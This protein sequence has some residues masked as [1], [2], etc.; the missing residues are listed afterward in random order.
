[1]TSL[2][3]YITPRIVLIGIVIASGALMATASWGETATFDETAHIPAGYAYVAYQDYRLNPEHPPIV[4]ILAGIPLVLQNFAFPTDHPAWK[5]LNEQWAIGH[6]FFYE[7][8]NDAD[9]IFQWA[10]VGPMALTLILVIFIYIWGKELIGRWWALLPA[11]LFGLSPSVLGHGHLVTTDVGSSLGIAVALYFFIRYLDDTSPYAH[12]N[13]IIYAGLA[14]GVAQLMKF[15]A[16][17]LIPL[18]VFL[19][20]VFY[21]W[22]RASDLY[23]HKSLWGY[24]KGITKIMVIGYAL[25]YLVYGAVTLNYPPKK[26]AEDTRVILRTFGGGEDPNWTSCSIIKDPNHDRLRCLAN[27]TIWMSD[28]PLLRPAAEYLLGVLMVIQRSAGGNAAYFLG[29]ISSNGWWYYFPTILLAKESI[30]AL[31]IIAFGIIMGI[32]SIFKNT[33]RPRQTL[34]ALQRYLGTHFA[35]FAMLSFIVLYWVYSIRSNLNIGFRHIL[36][37]L[38][39]TYLLAVSAIKHTGVNT[40][41][42]KKVIIGALIIWCAGETLMTAPYFLSYYNEFAGGT[43]EGYRIATDSNYDWGQ[44]LK[45]LQ[46]F[47]EEQNIQT[48]AIDYF[49]GGDPKWYLGDKAENWWSARGNPKEHGIEWMAVSVNSIQGALARLAP[50][51]PRKPQDEYKWLQELR[52]PLSPDFRAGTSIFIY[53]L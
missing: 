10:R 38:P 40:S 12:R 26:Q 4:K 11:F 23:H 39:F 41:Q 6:A 17:L 16:I 22:K 9:V 48:I 34:Q 2:V 50:T 47:V 37:T 25:V 35:E 7:L 49:G 52:D 27:A 42:I 8:G 15:S 30:P 45:R 19:I 14:F 18:F 1:M 43:Q 29:E 5:G 3:S 13:N 20:I 44:D 36:P 31:L 32:W 21:A 28:K 53:K 51:Q 46:V 33:G 24:I